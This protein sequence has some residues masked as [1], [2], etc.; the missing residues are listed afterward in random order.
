[1]AQAAALPA[2][3]AR[4]CGCLLGTLRLHKDWLSVMLRILVNA[5]RKARMG[6]NSI[7]T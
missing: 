6:R 1:M 2:V 3:H 5:S 4:R 7:G